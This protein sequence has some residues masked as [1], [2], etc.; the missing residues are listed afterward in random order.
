MKLDRAF[1]TRQDVV[2]IA[3]E[4]I[5]KYIFTHFEGGI[6]GGVI[7]ETEAY[8]G[9]TDRAS[10]AFGNRRTARTEVM[11]AGGGVAYVYLCYG[12]HSLFNIV[13]NMEGFPHAVLIRGIAP[14]Q[15]LDIMQT[16]IQKPVAVLGSGSGPGKV[17]KLLGIHY[18][19]SGIDLLGDRIWL[20]D[21]AM[22]FKDEIKT[23]TR[24]GVD[25]AGQDAS[26]LYR[27]WVPEEKVMN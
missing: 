15:G 3:K 13:T 16:R 1:Y 17:S 24:I 7:I 6:T 26:L 9:A 11:Y 18:S 12:I 2:Q 23:G 22:S 8:Q 25:Y 21:R 14:V 20:E 4:L 10:H 5:G 27:F 19:Y